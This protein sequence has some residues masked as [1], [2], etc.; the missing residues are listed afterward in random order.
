LKPIHLLAIDGPVFVLSFCLRRLPPPA[1]A[2]PRIFL[3]IALLS[4]LV[5]VFILPAG[6][7]RVAL[8]ESRPPIAGLD[9]GDVWLE[10]CAQVVVET[11]IAHSVE[12]PEIAGFRHLPLF[13]CDV[14][15]SILSGHRHCRGGMGV[16]TCGKG[17]AQGAVSSEP[18]AD[19][20]SHGPELDLAVIQGHYQLSGGRGE[21]PAEALLSALWHLL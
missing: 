20:L 17:L 8:K 16:Q 15:R 2:P 3:R 18:V 11:A 6:H 9:I 12:Q 21:D 14:L 4:A 5:G 13:G 10:S 19:E 7:I 1:P